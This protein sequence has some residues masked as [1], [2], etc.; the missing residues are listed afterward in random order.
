MNSAFEVCTT[1]STSA[2]RSRS[3]PYRSANYAKLLS[4]MLY[5]HLFVGIYSEKVWGEIVVYLG[6]EAHLAWMS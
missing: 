2:P 1:V 5:E 3:A 6:V 4:R